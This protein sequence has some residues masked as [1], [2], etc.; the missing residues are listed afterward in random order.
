MLPGAETFEAGAAGLVATG[1]W[2]KGTPSFPTQNPVPVFSG[3]NVWGTNLDGPYGDLTT[4]ALTSP[5]Y[6]LSGASSLTLSFH[7]YYW[8]DPDDGGQLQVWDA[9]QSR[10]V[11][12]EPV[13]GYP[14]DNIIILYYTGGYNGHLEAYEPAVFHLDSYAGGPFQFR[15]YFRSNITGHK[16]GSYIDDVALDLGNGLT[17]AVD[18]ASF[19]SADRPRIVWAGPNPSS[20]ESRVAFDNPAAA[21]VRLEVFALN[22]ARVRSFDLARFPAA[23]RK[24]VG[25]AGTRPAFQPAAGSSSIA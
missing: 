8:A 14:D 9:L 1:E 3:Q 18:P 17:L 4:S 5:V 23:G 7:H 15:F 13:G 20:R 19:T 2:G 10:W 12:V 25:T 11:V 22:G 21:A 16:L 24:R 6:D